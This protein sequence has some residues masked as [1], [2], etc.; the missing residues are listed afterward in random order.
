MFLAGR[1]RAVVFP[2][3]K[4]RPKWTFRSKLYYSFL[5][6]A[7]LLFYAQCTGRIDPC[8]SQGGDYR[9]EKRYN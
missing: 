9:C 6:V 1:E 4:L 8:D 2:I 5:G 7:D 3:E